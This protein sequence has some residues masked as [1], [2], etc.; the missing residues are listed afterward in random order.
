[1]A[2]AGTMVGTV[3]VGI[4]LPARVGKEGKGVVV[5]GGVVVGVELVIWTGGCGV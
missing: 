1:M 2:S 5:F 4:R 3:Y